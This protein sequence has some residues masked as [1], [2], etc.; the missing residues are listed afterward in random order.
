AD[1]DLP[2]PFRPPG[3]R[4]APGRPLRGGGR[5]AAGRLLGLRPA[6]AGAGPEGDEGGEQQQDGNE[7]QLGEEHGVQ[8]SFRQRQARRRGGGGGAQGGLGN[9]VNQGAG[10]RGGGMPRQGG[11]QCR[12]REGDAAAR[13]AL[14]E[15]LAGA[16]EPTLHGAQGPAEQ[17]GGLGIGLA[18]EVAQ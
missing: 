3:R 4:L 13:Q 1:D 10:Q 5:G 6:G 2:L 16:G 11:G 17:A 9:P 8:R 14:A 18:F 15:Q 7:F 12:R